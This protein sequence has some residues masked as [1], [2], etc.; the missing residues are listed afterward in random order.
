MT[1]RVACNVLG[2]FLSY[3]LCTF[4]TECHR[5]HFTA[6]C[7]CQSSSAVRS[8]ALIEAQMKWCLAK[9]FLMAH[10]YAFGFFGNRH[11]GRRLLSNFPSCRESTS[12]YCTQLLLKSSQVLLGYSTPMQRDKGAAGS[13]DGHSGG[14]SPLENSATCES[15]PPPAVPIENSCICR[16][17]HTNQDQRMGWKIGPVSQARRL[18]LLSG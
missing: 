15:D 13:V 5:W 14:G 16:G 6:L 2:K 18:F 7:V 8:A 4:G 17:A 11:L 12:P 10:L 1:I 9:V 3:L